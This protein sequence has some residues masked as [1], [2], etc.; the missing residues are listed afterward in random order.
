M[1]RDMLRQIEDF[2][3]LGLG[4]RFE[5]FSETLTK[6]GLAYWIR[7]SID[8]RLPFPTQTQNY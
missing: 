7:R 1:Y 3:G 5:G 2:E 6:G 8:P 4:G